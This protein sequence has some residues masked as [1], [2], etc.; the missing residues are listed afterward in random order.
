MPAR[1]RSWWDRSTSLSCTRRLDLH[2]PRVGDL[3][4]RNGHELE[5]GEEEVVTIM[6]ALAAAAPSE[7]P[8]ADGR[9]LRAQREEQTVAPPSRTGVAWG[10]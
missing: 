4:E 7:H 10:P 9:T 6:D 5:A 1:I 2:P 3:L 8:L